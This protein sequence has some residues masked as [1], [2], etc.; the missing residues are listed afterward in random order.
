MLSLWL[1]STC[2]AIWWINS[3]PAIERKPEVRHATSNCNPTR[4]DAPLR[5]LHPGF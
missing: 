2:A 5:F 3:E 4:C 1:V